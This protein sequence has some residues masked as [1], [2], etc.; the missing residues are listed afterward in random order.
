MK[1]ASVNLE[2]LDG[3]LSKLEEQLRDLQETV[4]G[5]V[6]LSESYESDLADEVERETNHKVSL[7]D[8]DSERLGN[9][10]IAL[11]QLRRSIA[12]LPGRAG[13]DRPRAGAGCRGRQRLIETGRLETAR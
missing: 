7:L 2:A 13:R 5:L 3:R 6:T 9:R 10:G 11:R 8:L 4:L 1:T 12:G